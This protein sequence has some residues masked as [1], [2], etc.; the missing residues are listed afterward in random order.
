MGMT[1]PRTQLAVAMLGLI[2]SGIGSHCATAG[3]T[4]SPH[5]NEPIKRFV[6]IPIDSIDWCDATAEEF[7]RRVTGA[8]VGK[9]F[10]S[11]DRSHFV[12]GYWIDTDDG[13]SIGL[14][15]FDKTAVVVGQRNPS[16]VKRGSFMGTI[17]RYGPQCRILE[18]QELFFQ[19]RDVTV[20][21]TNRDGDD[22]VIICMPGIGSI[23]LSRVRA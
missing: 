23:S 4:G 21:W 13:G 9:A 8:K 17:E 15:C 3:Q 22:D 6:T 7:R 20:F 18:R 16:H 1:Q 2:L 14:A 12:R 5:R 11:Y 10:T 19:D